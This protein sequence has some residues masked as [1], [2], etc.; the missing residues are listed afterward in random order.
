MMIV[1]PL[2]KDLKVYIYN[3]NIY[4]ILGMETIYYQ[5]QALKEMIE[6][7][8][9][10]IEKILPKEDINKIDMSLEE[11]E[12]KMANSNNEIL[13]SQIKIQEKICENPIEN[14]KLLVCLT[15]KSKKR[16]L[17]KGDEKKL[18]RKAFLKE[19]EFKVIWGENIKKV[20]CFRIF[21]N[22]NSFTKIII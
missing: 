2:M 15:F 22:L 7:D 17:I 4:I 9:Q 12:K 3:E 20:D 11:E 16:F 18:D 14:E 19:K 5:S 13:N 1:H 8:S 6:K 10:I 21:L